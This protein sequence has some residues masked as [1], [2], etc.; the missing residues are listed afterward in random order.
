MKGHIVRGRIEGTWYLR[1]ELARGADGRR[2][3]P[4]ETFRGTK[5]DA[6]QRLREL[7]GAVGSIETARIDLDEYKVTFD[8]FC[9]VR[10]RSPGKNACQVIEEIVQSRAENTIAGIAF[11]WLKSVESEVGHRTFVRYRQIV[12]DYIVPSLGALRT[13]TIRPLDVADAVASW[14]KAKSA[15]LKCPLSSRSI[16]HSYDTLRTVCR[17]ALR[18]GLLT[19]NPC[20]AVTPP[21]WE[22]REMSVLDSEGVAALL[23]AA[24]GTDLQVPIAVLVGTGLRRGELFG[25]RWTDVDIEGGKLTVRRSVFM[26]DGERREKPPKTARSTRTLA[27]A[28]FVVAALRTRKAEQLENLTQFVGEL[29]ARRLQ[30]N[31]Y[32]FDRADC[33]PW[34]PDSFSWSFAELVRRKKL[35]KVRLHDLRHSHAT[36][37]LAAGS[38]L[39]TI[40][41]ALGHSTIAITAN[42]YL[43]MTEALQRTHADRLEGLLGSSVSGALRASDEV[44][45]GTDSVPQS[46][47][48]PSRTKKKP[49]RSEVLMV[50]PTGF[51][52]VLP[53]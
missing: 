42:T 40:S 35:P 19:K 26:I 18:M 36:I 15:R 14:R 1:V 37:A 46:C 39:K 41:A 34:N 5:R 23:A 24:K 3:Q 16:R 51:E 53:P 47:H 20:D 25:L 44:V 21:R 31:A 2:R 48:T 9:A 7:L 6:E 27:L 52:P 49:R 30:R 45:S 28:P 32:V 29:E 13:D 33:S 4:R 43:H 11:D 12:N 10:L 22:Q 17:W 50:A 38:D 8:E